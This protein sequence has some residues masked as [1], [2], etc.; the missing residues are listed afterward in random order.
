MIWKM[1]GV[2][3]LAWGGVALWGLWRDLR[4]LEAALL[5]SHERQGFGHWGGG[6]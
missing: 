2:L 5:G 4:D 1:A 3:A 6:A